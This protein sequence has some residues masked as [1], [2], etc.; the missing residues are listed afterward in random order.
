MTKFCVQVKALRQ[1]KEFE[2]I[3]RTQPLEALLQSYRARH[4]SCINSKN[5]LPGKYILVIGNDDIGIGNNLPS[6]I[7]GKRFL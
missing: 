2:W 7:T 3:A 5:G 1:L 4:E 6:V